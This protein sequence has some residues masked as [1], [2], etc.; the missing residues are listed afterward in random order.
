MAADEPK[1][2][3]SRLMDLLDDTIKL[4]ERYGE[5]HWAQRL[6]TCRREML[7]HDAHGLSRLLAAYGGMGSFGDV[8]IAEANGHPIRRFDEDAVNQLLDAR[9]SEIWRLA[10]DLRRLD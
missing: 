3:V 10:R 9:R 6:T 5:T 2:D 1:G 4:L 8:L 7:A